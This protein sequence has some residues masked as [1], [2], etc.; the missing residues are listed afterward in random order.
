MPIQLNQPAI[1]AMQENLTKNL[2]LD[3]RL[4]QMAQSVVAPAVLAASQKMPD[5]PVAAA[6]AANANA[7]KPF[8]AAQRVDTIPVRRVEEMQ[9]RPEL[10]EVARTGESYVRLRVRASGD[11]L[12]I[13]SANEVDGPLITPNTIIG[14]HAYEVTLDGKAI[15]AEGLVDLGEQRS[16]PV[17]GTESHFI[18]QR[19]SFEFNVRIPKSQVPDQSLPRVGVTLYQFP[20]G[21]P[22]L[23]QGR[24][25]ATP[26]LQAKAVAQLPALKV[27]TLQ[28][29]LNQQLL[30]IFPKL[31]LP[32]K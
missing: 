22:R 28:P 31:V 20:D 18:T 3:A 2:V 7:M 4:P 13:V 12:Q 27:E 11:N 19:Q 8:D 24:I 1:G 14:A 21:A 23:L 26:G 32:P 9:G 6:S 5:Q 30:R 25:A 29:E 10:A 15:A 16:F 17:P